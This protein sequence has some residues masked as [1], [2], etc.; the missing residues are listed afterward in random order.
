RIQ[1][2]I[3][4]LQEQNIPYGLHSFG[5]L[6]PPEQVEST[7]DAIVSADRSL[8]PAASEVLAVDMHERITSS[9]ARETANLLH[10]LAGGYLPGGNGGEPIRNPD[11]YPTG[12][13]FFG[14]DPDKVPKK[15]SWDLGV[16]LA[17]QMLE[18]HLAE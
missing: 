7:V 9:A 2:H 10:G 15:A 8:L 18:E 4:E 1:D 13:N 3:L 6:P 16:K 11:A 14:I 17:D 12:K 5:R